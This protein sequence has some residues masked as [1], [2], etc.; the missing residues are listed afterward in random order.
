MGVC[1]KP[2]CCKFDVG[3][4]YISGADETI[5]IVKQR[6]SKLVQRFYNIPVSLSLSLLAADIPMCRGVTK[7]LMN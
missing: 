2:D 6:I 4:S 1:G 3:S 5:T 7:S